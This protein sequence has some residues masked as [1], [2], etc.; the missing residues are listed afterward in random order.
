MP[1]NTISWRKTFAY[2][3]A[4][5]VKAPKIPAIKLIHMLSPAIHKTAESLLDVR[6]KLA[7]VRK[8]RA[9]TIKQV[10]I[11]PNDWLA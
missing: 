1:P 7:A 8:G 9:Q 5:A 3:I 11:N 6:Y 4:Q 10:P 2:D